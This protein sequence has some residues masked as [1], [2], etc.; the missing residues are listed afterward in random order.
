M[1]RV[2]EVSSFCAVGLPLCN[3]NPSLSIC[4][5]ILLHSENVRPSSSVAP[6]TLGSLSFFSPSLIWIVF[7]EPLFAVEDCVMP[8]KLKWA[9]IITIFM[10]EYT[11]P[12]KRDLA[13]SPSRLSQSLQSPH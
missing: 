8:L 7:P 5:E 4:V 13:F 11:F 9:V 12:P 6:L 10:A 1:N 3:V 2:N